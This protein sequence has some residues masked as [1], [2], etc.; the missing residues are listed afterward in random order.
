MKKLLSQVFFVS[1]CARG[2]A[3]AMTLFAVGNM[4]WISLF[5]LLALGIGKITPPLAV[6]W[7]VGT[8]LISCYGLALAIVTVVGL[9][10]V[11]HRERRFQA[12]RYL[13][14]S[15]LCLAAGLAGAIRTFP[16]VAVFDM[17]FERPYPWSWLSVGVPGL[18]PQYSAAVFG[19]SLLLIFAGGLLLTAMF[20]AAEGKKFRA[21]FGPAVLTLWGT[22]ILWYFGMLGAALYASRET[23]Q[24]QQAVER[25]F[26]RPLTAEGLA[27]LYRENGKPDAAFWTR[28]EKLR[29]ALPK[30]KIAE[31]QG[32]SS[33]HWVPFP[34]IQLPDR[35]TS[36]TLAWHDRCC[37]ENRAAI[38]AWERCFD[39]EPP[40]PEKRFAR[41][42][43]VAV[44][45]PELSACRDLA[46]MERGRLIRGLAAGDVETARTCYRRMGN[47]TAFLRKEPWLQSSLTWMLLEHERLDWVEKMLASRLLS[48]D[49]LEE[50][51]ADLAAL[52]RAIPLNH[53]QAMYSEAVFG[54]DI[55]VM[56]ADE[57]IEIDR[58]RFFAPFAPYRWIFPQFWLHAALDRR[59][60]LRSYLQPDLA[61][62]Q[63]A[64]PPKPVFLLSSML[65]PALENIGYRF[66][67]LTARVRGMRVL[68]RAEKYRRQHGE[69]PKMMQDLPED[70]FTGRPLIYEIGP[71]EIA[72]IVWKK[73]VD[74]AA[75]EK[76][77]VDAVQVHS[78][79][80]AL[81][82]NIRRYP[83]KG[84]DLTR[85]VLR[86]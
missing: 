65:L 30:V 76:R 36:E 75:W 50:L 69:F 62:G 32:L 43:L 59:N 52:E 34:A 60:I 25:R 70:P 53:R 4:L 49:R 44:L 54:Q 61:H 26:G 81:P 19:L 64:V 23:A 51:D 58:A 7:G 68:I 46:R 66:Y 45:L 77:T 12:L 6:T 18:P 42:G 14:P 84:T 57:P 55:L 41:G 13:L 85:A 78:D 3:F 22:C 74:L 29:D 15:G 35:P 27:A 16:P 5:H 33:E 24:V 82:E 9:V 20:A 39:R 80:A 28:Q 83:G 73:T 21:A 31:A 71:T 17:G 1:D 10:K 67:A 86:K 8:L 79:P 40:P 2:A 38:E 48:D 63:G 47:V 72:E 11:L 37:R 56:F